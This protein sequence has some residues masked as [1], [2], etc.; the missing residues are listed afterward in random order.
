LVEAGVVSTE[1]VANAKRVLKQTPGKNLAEI[2]SDMG[3][4]EADVLPVVAE[5]A[6]LPFERVDAKDMSAFDAKAVQRLGPKFCQ[7]NVVLPLRREGSRLVVGTSSPHDVFVLDDVKRQLGVPSIKH[8]LVT[9]GDIKAVID[10]LTDGEAEDYDVEE[11]LIDVD[12]DDVEVLKDQLQDAD[13]KDADSSPVVRLVNHIIQSALKENASDIHIEPDERE[14]KV[15]LRIDG[16][17]FDLMNPPK[18]MHAA[19]TSR[20]KIMSN[21]DI[22]ER[23]AAPPGRPH[24]G[25]GARS[26]ARPARLHHPHLAR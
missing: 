4:H 23:R 14:L 9:A 11:M 15:R 19:M 13:A 26:Q 17:L 10:T 8:V 5:M 24:P 2:L 1:L 18:K 12:E 21:L 6:R 20:I 16:V 25:H 3:A 22:A 7:T